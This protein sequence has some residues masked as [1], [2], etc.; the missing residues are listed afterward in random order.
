[1]L[2]SLIATSV[3][4]FVFGLSLLLATLFVRFSGSKEKA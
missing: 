1:M 2:E 3:T 4:L